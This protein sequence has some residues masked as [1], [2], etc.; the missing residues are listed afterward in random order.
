MSEQDYFAQ[1]AR[2]RLRSWSPDDAPALLEMNSVPEVLK[3]VN[4]DRADTPNAAERWIEEQCEYWSEHG[5]GICVVEDSRS[6]CF[7]GWTGLATP[8]FLPELLPAVDIGW[9]IRRELWGRGLATEAGAAVLEAAFGRL[10]M[11]EVYAVSNPDNTASVRVMEKLGMAFHHTAAI[12]DT[13]L[14]VDVYIAQTPERNR[15]WPTSH[16]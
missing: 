14:P 8:T 15:A 16:A 1:T 7:L 2:T 13:G 11:H 10:G 5:Y 12:P 4:E 9:R 3:Y 6:G